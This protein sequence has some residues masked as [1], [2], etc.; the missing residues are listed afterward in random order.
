[1]TVNRGKGMRNS[2]FDDSLDKDHVKRRIHE[3]SR[4]KVGF[5]S[6]GLYPAS[7]AYNSA[8]QEGGKSLLL[9]PRPGRKLLGAFSEQAIRGMDPGHVDQM[10]RMAHHEEGNQRVSNSLEYLIRTCDLVIL[11]AN[12]NY[13]EADLAEARALRERLKRRSVVFACLAGSYNHDTVTDS[14]YVLCEKYPNLAF[15]SGFHRHDALR[16]PFDSFTAN[17]CHPNALTALLGA[18][19]LDKLSLN[20]QVAPGVHNVEAQYIKAAKNMGSIFAGFGYEYHCGNSG[21]LPT[22]LTLILDQCLDQAATVSMRRRDR[23]NLYYQQAIPLTELG[24]G[25]AGIEAM[26]DRG[27]DAAIARDH[28]FSQLTAMVAD[29]RGSMMMPLSGKPTRNFQAGQ[30]LARMMRAQGRCPHSMVE[31]EEWCEEAGLKKGGLEGV[32]ALRYWPQIREQYGIP[33]HDASMVNLLY[34]VLC[35]DADDKDAAFLVMTESRE[36]SNYCQ[37]SVRPTHSR[38]YSGA[39]N[40]LEKPESMELL[41][42]AVIADTAR[43]AIFDENAADEFEIQADDP[44]YLQAMSSIEMEIRSPSPF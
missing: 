43:K 40:N 29:V 23:H 24:Y 21:I 26:I 38:K 34:T 41:A 22:L 32:K 5:Y 17:F 31:Y 9:A 8:M 16:D 11:S 42:N 18:F 25:V 4:A 35:G 6:I 10:H 2:F 20:I 39:L 15:F 28:T 33:S 30:V 14:S 7:L 12:S 36:L 13:I 37:E 19:I 44:A 27:G 1:M 3:L